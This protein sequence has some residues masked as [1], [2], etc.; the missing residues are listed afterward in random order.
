M[1]DESN[2]LRICG[3]IARRY[4]ADYVSPDVR[5][6][7]CKISKTNGCSKYQECSKAW[8]NLCWAAR[9][10]RWCPALRLGATGDARPNPAAILLEQCGGRCRHDDP[11]YRDCIPC[12]FYGCVLPG[13]AEDSDETKCPYQ[14]CYRDRVS[15]D[16]PRQN[17][18]RLLQCY[19]TRDEFRTFQ[20]DDLRLVAA[21]FLYKDI[22]SP[23]VP[24][25]YLMKN[26][27]A[28]L[29]FTSTHIT[30]REK[31]WEPLVDEQLRWHAIAAARKEG[32]GRAVFDLLEGVDPESPTTHP[33]WRQSQP[34]KELGVIVVEDGEFSAFL[35]RWMCLRIAGANGGTFAPVALDQEVSI[36]ISEQESAIIDTL[37]SV[38]ITPESPVV[39]D[40]LVRTSIAI[41]FRDIGIVTADRRPTP[42]M[43]SFASW[44]LR[45]IDDRREHGLQGTRYREISFCTRNHDLLG[46]PTSDEA[47]DDAISLL[48]RLLSASRAET[49]APVPAEDLTSL[50][51]LIS[52]NGGG[53]LPASEELAHLE[54]FCRFPLAG[55]YQVRQGLQYPL[56][57]V[58]FP[59]LMHP[60]R[61]GIAPAVKDR[62]PNRPVGVFIGI[63]LQEHGLDRTDPFTYA[64][65]RTRILR[66]KT[67]GNLIAKAPNDDFID[68]V[69]QKYW[70]FTGLGA[71]GQ[72]AIHYIRNL[73]QRTSIEAHLSQPTQTTGTH[74]K[75]LNE[76]VQT[77]AR[78]EEIARALFQL[79]VLGEKTSVETADLIT[80]VEQVIQ[81]HAEA[82]REWRDGGISVTWDRQRIQ[83]PARIPCDP[84]VLRWFVIEELFRNAA[85][86]A[87]QTESPTRFILFQLHDTPGFSVLVVQNSAPKSLRQRLQAI[88][89]PYLGEDGRWHGLGLS[90]ARDVTE[91]LGGT[92]SVEPDLQNLVFTVTVRMPKTKEEKP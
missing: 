74:T 92:L 44:M 68:N 64:D 10:R 52:T 3:E 73:S 27:F 40:G 4:S 56:S 35:V 48:C 89:R 72:A 54:R 20:R 41:L 5:S 11:N 51:R 83:H 60:G 12:P 2:F 18:F 34:E 29:Q 14:W 79:G 15:L 80:V 31:P 9:E 38:G 88:G 61:V 86:A 76:T 33:V 55:H 53:G 16:S 22:F 69:L 58:V 65:F 6:E 59:V 36:P 71:A 91:T 90:T 25:Y 81:A 70:A 62:P 42:R 77:W 43:A 66:T 37:R 1:T 19:V 26:P 87:E 13:E 84:A 57:W 23:S 50:A 32:V 7:W 30:D 21:S 49:P 28:C 67:V 45:N 82:I 17:P 8:G 75:L 85:K 24:I 63:A 78:V 39:R 47:L 46:L